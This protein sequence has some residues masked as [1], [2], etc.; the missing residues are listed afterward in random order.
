MKSGAIKLKNVKFEK[1]MEGTFLSRP[2]RFT[3]EIR[4]K[5]KVSLAHLHDPGRLKELLIKGAT[6]LF[7]HSS[8]KLPYYLRAVKTSDELVLIDSS[9]HSKIAEEIFQYIP[10]LTSF[11]TI[12]KEVKFGISRIDFSLDSVPLEVK[13]CTLVINNVALFPDAPTKRG[14]RHVMEIIHHKGIILFLIFVKA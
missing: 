12:K 7:T 1:L 2:N 4:Y 11:K 5:E 13:G 10:E 14:T 3:S 9:I 6:V 8:G